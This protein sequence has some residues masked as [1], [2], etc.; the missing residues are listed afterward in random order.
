M[1]KLIFIALF[2]FSSS[3]M[4]A[5]PLADFFFQKNNTSAAVLNL[6][7]CAINYNDDESQMKLA[8]AYETGGYGLEPD[9]K[10]ALYF[11]QLA[12]ETGN[13][14]AQ[15]TLAK[16][17]MKIDEVPERRDNL[18]KYRQKI[19]PRSTQIE[20]SS[21]TGDFI[22]PYALLML[23]SE[24]PNQKWYYPSL[25]RSPSPEA[26]TLLKVYKI[27]P[28]KKQ[29]AM[30]QASQFKTRKLLQAAKEVCTN[31]EYE[32]IAH[33]LK[34]HQTQSQALTELKEKMETYI[35][36]KKEYKKSK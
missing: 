16:I 17:F 21:F 3:A 19:N 23:A 26:V 11:Y 9:Q 27:T 15:L 32:D 14:E 13:S 25:V 10:M 28:E 18:L 24:S 35:Q 30:K 36:K 22:H 20:N 8:Q 4:A 33:R 1:R 5:C 12:A 6:H 2:L 31:E 29:Q 7:T 34:N